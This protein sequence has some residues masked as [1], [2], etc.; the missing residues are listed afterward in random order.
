MLTPSVHP[1][2]EGDPTHAQAA[3]HPRT[4]RVT[5]DPFV[6][7]LPAA[8]FCEVCDDFADGTCR[9]ADCP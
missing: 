4:H 9:H 3:R 1:D 2:R 8:V 7:D 5:A 6:A